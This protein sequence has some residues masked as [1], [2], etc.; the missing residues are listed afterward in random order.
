MSKPNHRA[1]LEKVLSNEKPD[2]IPISFWRHFP[3]DDQN[4]ESLARAVIDHQMIYDFDFIKVTPASSYC[5]YDYGVRDEWRGNPE[6]TRDYSKALINKSSEYKNIRVLDPRKGK[7]DAQLKC[8]ALLHKN[9]PDSTPFIQTIFSPLA[10]LKHLVGNHQLPYFLRCHP[11]ESIEMI[12]TITKTTKLF[13]EEC[14][15]NKIDGIFYAVQSATYDQFSESEYLTFGKPFDLD[16]LLHVQDLWLNILHI[17]GN[18]IMFDIVREYPCQIFNWHDR[19]TSPSL[20]EALINTSKVVCGGLRRIDTMLLGSKQQVRNEI[21][22]AF[23]Q[24][25]GKRWIL[26]TGCVLM[27]TTPQ[28]NIRSA[29]EIINSLSK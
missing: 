8:L 23:E 26:S 7:L 24:T 10:Q 15:K 5:L 27:L 21:M 19:E 12:K 22:D 6:G 18:N 20:R 4:P 16:I 17:H 3:V 29:I 25:G 13:I 14:K 9:L 11:D 28:G 2:R 1:R